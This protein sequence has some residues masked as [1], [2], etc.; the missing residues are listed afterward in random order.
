MRSAIRIAALGLVWGSVIAV[1]VGF[2]LPWAQVD[3]NARPVTGPLGRF[4]HGGSL[5]EAASKLSKRVGKIVIHV[6][7]G[8][9]TITGELPD[10]S[11][12]PTQISG[13]Q[14][15]Q[16]AHRQDIAAMLALTQLVTGKEALG[17][18]SYLVMLV[19]LL[20]LCCGLL[21]TFGERRPLIS[22]T[23][24]L[25]ALA[26][27]VAGWW[28]LSTVTQQATMVAVS[29]GLGLWLSVWAYLVLG[30]AGLCVAISPRATAQ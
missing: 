2:F 23:A 22:G 30:V 9:E 7:R 18:K 19:P 13:W 8:T 21:V 14:I 11:K 4:L 17:A 10:F 3:A 28:K 20:A 15:P 12:L 25:V 16:F 1:T 29:I 5:Q 27:G 24:A 6:Q 26:V